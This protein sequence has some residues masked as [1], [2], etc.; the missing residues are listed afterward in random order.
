MKKKTAVF[1]REWE[2]TPMLMD[3]GKTC[4]KNN[5]Q[6]RSFDNS[7]MLSFIILFLST[8]KDLSIESK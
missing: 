5:S 6:S 4:P 7:V 2:E 8:G 1:K 3:W